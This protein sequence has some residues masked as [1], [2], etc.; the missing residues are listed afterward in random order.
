MSVIEWFNQY[1]LILKDVFH[2]VRLRKKDGVD[3]VDLAVDDLEESV[4]VKRG[5]EG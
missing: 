2:A 1:W 5:R 4:P 3:P